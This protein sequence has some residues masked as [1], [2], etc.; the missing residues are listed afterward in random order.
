MITNRDIEVVE[1]LKEFKVAR[2]DTLLAL[3]YPSLRIAQERLSI[4][5]DEKLIKRIRDHNNM[6]YI[7]YTKM[8][9]QLKHSLLV[10]DF[11]REL[12]KRSD[13]VTFKIEPQY[14]SIR[15]DAVF[16]YM[17]GDKGKIGL[18]EAE[19][20][21]KGFDWNKYIRFFGGEYKSHLPALP[22]LCIVGDKISPS[23]ADK[24]REMG[25]RVAI[26][27]TDFSNM[28]EV[29]GGATNNQG[30]GGQSGNINASGIQTVERRPCNILGNGWQDKKTESAGTGSLKARRR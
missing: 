21:H 27:K 8:P 17:E 9:E 25:V 20:S 10:T 23:G 11:Y 15:P 19:I 29:Y 30:G 5:T 1:F 13:K 28:G 4:L 22:V 7:Y 14:G 18:L 6:Q 16:G 24:L 12:R 26:I 2:R 3:F